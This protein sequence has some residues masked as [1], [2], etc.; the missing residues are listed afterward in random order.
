LILIH[1]GKR[2]SFHASVTGSGV[3][4]NRIFDIILK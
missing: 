3:S 4:Y 1:L 2:R